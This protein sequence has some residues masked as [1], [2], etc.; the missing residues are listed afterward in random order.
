MNRLD[1]VAGDRAAPTSPA[2]TPDSAARSRFTAFDAHWRPERQLTV[3]TDSVTARKP[4][5]HARTHAPRLT[6]R[7]WVTSPSQ[8]PEPS[9]RTSIDEARFTSS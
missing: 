9:A 5:V 3:S 2:W 8:P 7:Q 6:E 4:S 1:D